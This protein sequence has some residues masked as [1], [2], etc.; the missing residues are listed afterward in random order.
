MKTP[1]TCCRKGKRVRL[2]LRNGEVIFG[3]F[4]ERTGKFIILDIGRYRGNEI[5][6]FSIARI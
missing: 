2:A 6:A 1:H 3:K 4:I 5:S